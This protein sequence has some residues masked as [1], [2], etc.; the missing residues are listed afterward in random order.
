M[1]R[2]FSLP[3]TREVEPATDEASPCA[4]TTISP[5]ARSGGRGPAER[6]ASSA[7]ALAVAA[8]G[9]DEEYGTG[10]GSGVDVTRPPIPTPTSS[11]ATTTT[12]IADHARGVR[13]G[14]GDGAVI[15][16][17]P[18]DRARGRLAPAGRRPD[19]R[20]PRSGTMTAWSWRSARRGSSPDRSGTDCADPPGAGRCA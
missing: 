17:P 14:A 13:V 9:G 20:R 6:A 11:T 2:P 1:P 8:D 15:E 5:S 12:T 10:V 3:T 19:G 4:S 7:G 18:R 16:P